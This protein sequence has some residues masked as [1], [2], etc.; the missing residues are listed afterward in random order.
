MDKA[1]RH[2]SI[3]ASISIDPD[4]ISNL[5]IIVENRER[6]KAVLAVIVT[7]MLKKIISPNQDIRKHQAG[8]QDGFSARGLDSSTVT[9]FLKDKD[10]PYM[11]SG[12]EALTR[13]LEQAVPYDKDYTG[14]I[15]PQRV[16]DAFL[17]LADAMQ[18]KNI[19]PNDTL[20]Y[21]FTKLI[22]YRDLDK[23]IKLNRPI[24]MSIRDIV[25]KINEH[26][27]KCGGEGSK[28][29][30]LAIYAVYK[31]LVVEFQRY[32]NCVLCDLQEHNTADSRSGFLGD[33]Q[34]NRPDQQP[35][36][37]VEIKHNIKLSP[38]LVD[39]CYDKF[40]S[41]PV[42][43]YYLLSTNETLK[44]AEAIS[45]RILNIQ[46]NHGCQMI[47]NGI[48]TSLKY[49]LRLL[50]NPHDFLHQYV[51]LIEDRGS[52]NVKMQWQDLWK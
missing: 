35:F 25:S 22:E 49:Y 37:I 7:L 16:K 36:E 45:E 8:M 30:V 31:Q 43:T 41:A 44:D 29:P 18:I 26:F 14:H 17:F 42:K 33:V 2:S 28:L 23:N 15:K 47:V 32:K 20:I 39:N 24:N 11:V 19:N 4:T 1:Y 6:C 13:S 50:E 48:Q 12:A 21:L 10:F 3:G 46:K 52:Y 27:E 38:D 40:K 34:V 5:D 51:D 9:P